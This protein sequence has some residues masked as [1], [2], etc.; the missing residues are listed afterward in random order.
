VT[1]KAQETGPKATA[2]ESVSPG[3]G[4]AAKP[5]K[6]E[7]IAATG[8]WVGLVGLLITITYAVTANSVALWAECLVTVL[9]FLCVLTAWLTLRRVGRG[10]AA[11]G[12]ALGRLESF[13]SLG[14]GQLMVL[15]FVLIMGAAAWK[16]FHPSPIGGFG[17]YL[18]ICANSVYSLINGSL[19]SRSLKMERSRPSPTI[20]AQ[21]RLYSVKTFSNVIM[22]VAMGLAL[23]FRSQLWAQ[24]IDPVF[25][26]FIGVALILNATKT[27]RSSALNLIDRSLEERDQLLIMRALTEHYHDFDML[28]GVRTRH[29]GTQDF[30]EL[31]LEFPPERPMGQV[32]DV[33]DHLKV[34]IRDLLGASTDV[35]VIPTTEP[36]PEVS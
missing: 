17:V 18:A 5:V 21:R 3:A 36:P 33:I 4:V 6:R 19:L 30:V 25:S 23:G 10:A 27:V 26:V 24:Y 11:S 22:V 28:H 9:D 32:Q 20:S 35:S 1:D 14:I 15:S 12:P 16:A 7:S 31:F 34:T 8:T 13:A 2:G 29:S